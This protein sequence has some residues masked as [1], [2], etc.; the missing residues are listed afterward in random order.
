MT[1]SQLLFR[2]LI[3]LALGNGND[4]QV[5]SEVNWTEVVDIAFSQGLAAIAC[6]GLQRLYEIHPEIQL[7]LDA[8]E[9]E[10]V[11]YEWFGSALEAENN[12]SQH[13]LLLE[14]ICNLLKPNEIP[15][16]LMKG[17]GVGLNY[18]VPS[19]RPCGDIDIYTGRYKNAVN[20]IFCRKFG[21]SVDEDNPK[22]SKMVLKGI[23]VENHGTFSDTAVSTAEQRAEDILLEIIDKKGYDYEASLPGN[24]ALLPADANYIFLLKHLCAHFR[25][26]TSASIRQVLDLGLFLATHSDELDIEGDKA[27]VKNLGLSKLNDI[28]VSIAEDFSGPSLKNFYIGKPSVNDVERVLRDLLNAHPNEVPRPRLAMMW[29]KAKSALG[30][31]WKYKYYPDNWQ[32]IMYGIRHNMVRTKW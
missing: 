24:C 23:S 10:D 6:D 7:T 4:C 2:D 3:R 18:P 16:C 1:P 20:D 13:R 14:E 5:P 12:Y 9:Y 29:Y 30:I 19:H 8:A 26:R 22:H 31:L 28:F 15:V 17:I 32:R 11:K 27:I 25:T 21:A